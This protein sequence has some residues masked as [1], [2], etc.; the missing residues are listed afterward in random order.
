MKQKQLT[1]II[2]PVVEDLGFVLWG[3]DYMP[4][5]SGALLRVYIDHEQGISVDDCADCSREISA[6]ME[7]EDPISSAY[8][9]EVS[10]PGLDRVLFDA[11]QFSQYLG[12]QAKVKLAQPVNGSRKIT[13]YI[14][15]VNQ[16]EITLV[17]EAGEYTFIM[18]NVM[19]ARLQPQYD[20]VQK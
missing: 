3:I 11:E 5:K 19:K 10:S 4:Q 20:G 17:N 7:V 16:D 9:L 6:V 14:K 12:D 1:E 2:Q 15:S 13:G 8:V 18:S